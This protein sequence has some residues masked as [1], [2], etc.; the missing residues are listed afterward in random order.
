M[1]KSG[2]GLCARSRVPGEEHLLDLVDAE[3]KADTA[4]QGAV[5]KRENT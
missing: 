5:M 1:K 3:G 4:G 2:G